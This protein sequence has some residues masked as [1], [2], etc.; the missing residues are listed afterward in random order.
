MHKLAKQYG[1]SPRDFSPAMIEACQAYSW[2]GNLR[3]LESFVKRYLMTG[4]KV[5]VFEKSR[6]DLDETVEN[7]ALT[8]PRALN[9]CNHH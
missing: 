7:A 4:D 1:L 2:P 5:Q 9:G 3:E 6:P 8:S